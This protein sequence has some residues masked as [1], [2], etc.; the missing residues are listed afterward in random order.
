MKVVLKP[1]GILLILSVIAVLAWLVVSDQ[2][3]ILFAPAGPNASQGFVKAATGS[4]SP[5]LKTGRSASPAAPSLADRSTGSL[6]LTRVGKTDWVL[7]GVLPG[8]L[9]AKSLVRKTAPR[10]SIESVE[11]VG[12]GAVAS[13][14]NDTRAFRWADGPDGNSTGADVRTGAVT[15]GL[16]SGFRVVVAPT[17]GKKQTLMVWVGG[18]GVRSK[19][20]ARMSDGTPLSRVA[21]S[22]KEIGTG[23]DFAFRSLY[24]VYFAATKPGQKLVLSYLVAE[25]GR[26]RV[27][28]QEGSPPAE[29]SVSLQ[30]IAVD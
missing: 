8:T 23:G 11:F 27:G 21:E 7:Y 18:A 15:E 20:H 26:S 19:L 28:T 17:V 24:T 5:A 2:A 9:P 25:E 4:A 14:G 12:D 16:G 29:S 30:A 1:G 10:R 3:K 6:D 22:Y 13:Y